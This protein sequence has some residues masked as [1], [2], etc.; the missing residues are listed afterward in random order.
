MDF[1]MKDSYSFE[2][3]SFG[4]FSFI[5]EE[6]KYIW[7]AFTKSSSTLFMIQKDKSQIR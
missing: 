6:N 4:V 5:K 3:D 7:G 2:F 1:S